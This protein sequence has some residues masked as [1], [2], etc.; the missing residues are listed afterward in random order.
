[1][2]KI[3]ITNKPLKEN[4]LIVC[5]NP[6]CGK[7]HRVKNSVEKFSDDF[8]CKTD[9]LQYIKC[10]KDCYLVGFKGKALKSNKR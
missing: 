4:Q 6:K 8:S 10:G 2:G 1:M 7:K 9:L 5:P 3:T